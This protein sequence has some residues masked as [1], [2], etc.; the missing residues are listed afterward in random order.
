MDLH[1]S[2]CVFVLSIS[3]LEA[4]KTFFHEIYYVLKILNFVLPNTDYNNV[5]E[6]EPVLASYYLGPWTMYVSPTASKI[7]KI[8]LR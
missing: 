3:T 2:L 8:L 1:L 7:I 6:A 4:V 5:A